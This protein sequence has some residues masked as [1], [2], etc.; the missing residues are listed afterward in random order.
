[1]YHIDEEI[2]RCVCELFQAQESF[3]G[4]TL[5]LIQDMLY[6]DLVALRERKQYDMDRK[7]CRKLSKADPSDV[8]SILARDQ[9]E[10]PDISKLSL[11]N[12]RGKCCICFETIVIN[13]PNPSEEEDQKGIAFAPCDH[14]YCE[15][16]VINW[17][18]ERI[19]NKTL[20][21]P[22]VCAELGCHTEIDPDV[23]GSFSFIPE[24]IQVQFAERHWEV[25]GQ[26]MFCP[27]KTCAHLVVVRSPLNDDDSPL[28][29]CPA[30]K[31][32]VCFRCRALHYPRY[33]CAQFQA[34]PEEERNPDDIAAL[35][36]ARDNHWKRCPSCKSIVERTIGCNYMKCIC[37]AAFC[38]PRGESYLSSTPTAENTHGQPGCECGL[39]DALE[40]LEED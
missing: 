17:I 21:F 7:L 18:T 15:S 30:C 6:A 1:V 8:P 27:H 19:N 20:P 32:V 39:F 4:D 2:D 12:P 28:V 33:T 29:E 36:L 9:W 38:Y 5:L 23:L 11:V 10:L 37:G 22:M 24:P 14:E 35:S 26:A 16:C 34:L 40:E 31:S 3:E 13:A 25:K